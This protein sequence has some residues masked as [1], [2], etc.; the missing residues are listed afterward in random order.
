M[1]LGGHHDSISSSAPH[2]GFWHRPKNV[3][4]MRLDLCCSSCWATVPLFGSDDEVM[5]VNSVNCLVGAGELCELPGVRCGWGVLGE[6][7]ELPGVRWVGA[8]GGELPGVRGRGWG[9][10]LSVTCHPSLFDRC[11]LI[12]SNNDKGY[13]IGPINP[14]SKFFLARCLKSSQLYMKE[15]NCFKCKTFLKQKKVILYTV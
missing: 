7:F 4:A 5:G 12:L 11:P 2:L 1:W 10:D 6:L 15:N 9:G 14:I 3:G 13:T 8:V